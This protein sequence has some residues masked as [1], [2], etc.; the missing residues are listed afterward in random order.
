M[1]FAGVTGARGNVAMQLVAD[2]DFAMLVGT[3]TTITRL[4]YQNDVSWP[5][6]LASLSSFTFN[7]QF[8]ETTFYLLGLGGGGV[9]NISGTVNGVDLT[10][11]NVLMSSDIGAYLTD[12]AAQSSGG[13]VENGTYNVSLLDVQAALSNLTWGSPTPTDPGVDG[14]AGQSPTGHGFHFDPS[15]AHLFQFSAADVNVSA[16]PEPSTCWLLMG[17]GAA[18]ALSRYRRS[19]P[20]RV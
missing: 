6:Q 16:I 19:S 17:A 9:E 3:N 20:P 4:I 10:T 7:L 18:M 14:V 2:N 8:G 13:T 5:A 1:L 12:F 11:I 15:S